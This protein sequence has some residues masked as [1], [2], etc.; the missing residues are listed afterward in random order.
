IKDTITVPRAPFNY[1]TDTAISTTCFGLQYHDG[2]IHVQGYSIP[3]GPF[4]Y[5]VDN[6]PF[7][8][9]PDFFDLSA[10]PHLVT[11][12]DHYGCDTTFT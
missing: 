5:S 10:G 11:A 3:N 6:S 7:Q 4:Q 1:Y 12:Q 2:I 9:I 8:T